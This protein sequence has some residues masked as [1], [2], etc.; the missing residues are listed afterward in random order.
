M[1]Q[2]LIALFLAVMLSPTAA[3]AHGD[4]TTS[5]PASGDRVEEP[6]T[7]ISISFGEPPTKDSTYSVL[8]GCGDEVLS[9]VEGKGT[10][11]SLVVSGGSSGRW[12]VS[13]NVI[14]ATD[15]HHSK[16]S[17]SFRVAGEKECEPETNESPSIGDAAPPI[18]PDDEPAS[19]PVVPIAIGA[20]IVA[21]AIALRL[22][23]SK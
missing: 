20:G 6:P 4:V 2:A 7:E 21:G 13:Y 15:G 12:K 11:K 10:E 3:W 19:F 14:S 9:S 8:D 5:A 22:L 23:G 1:R 18:P 17:Y 16:D